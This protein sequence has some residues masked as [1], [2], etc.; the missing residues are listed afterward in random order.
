VLVPGVVDPNPTVTGLTDVAGI[1]GLTVPE[2]IAKPLGVGGMIVSDINDPRLENITLNLLGQVKGFEGL[3]IPQATVDYM[4]WV[5]PPG[6]EGDMG[7]SI[8]QGGQ[9]SYNPF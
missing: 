7:W 4:Q 6:P 3:A 9:P 5:D 8:P 1:V 2:K